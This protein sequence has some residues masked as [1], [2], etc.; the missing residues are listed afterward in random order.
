[1]SD[2]RSLVAEYLGIPV[3][4]GDEWMIMCPAPEHT[5]HR[6]SA[7]IYVGE[8]V[9]RMRGGKIETRMPGVWTCYSCHRAGRISNDAIE[10]YTPSTDRNL[11]VLT[12]DLE[13]LESAGPRCYPE[14]WLDL[15]DFPHPYWRERFSEETIERHRLG[16]DFAQDAL[17]YPFRDPAGRVLGVVYRTL[18]QDATGWKYKYPRGIDK[19]TLLYGYSQARQEDVETVVLVEGALDAI[20]VDEAGYTALAIYGS[21][22]SEPQA[23]LLRRLYPE[24]LIFCFDNDAAGEAALQHCFWSGELMMPGFD[25]RKVSFPSGTKDIAELDLAS[26]K[27]V[28]ADAQLM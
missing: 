18:D 19:S 2:I 23:L 24:K 27:Q 21:R 4:G 11:E 15:F 1:M 5:D 16:Y 14:S 17:T 25:F 7:S 12:A 8:P 20:A 9:K 22:M 13:A 26:R 3:Q 10:N 28:L 6:P